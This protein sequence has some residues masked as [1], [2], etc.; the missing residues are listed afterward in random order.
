MKKLILAL[1]CVLPLIAASAHAFGGGHGGHGGG[2]HGGFRGGGGF[3]GGSSFHGGGGYYGGHAMRG[4]GVP[5]G[6]FHPYARSYGG[7]RVWA[8]PAV[9]GAVGGY[10]LMAPRP[11][12]AAPAANVWYY[13]QSYGAYYPSV[14]Y[15]PEGWM[16]VPA[17]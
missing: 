2:G 8:G 11:V 7:G 17:Y 4:G 1:V 9:V 10:A 6:N 12:Y 5:G 14:Q 3:P 16:P 13:C 15:C